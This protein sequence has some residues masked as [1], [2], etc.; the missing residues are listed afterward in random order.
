LDASP[1]AV[2]DKPHCLAE[3]NGFSSRIPVQS[4][5]PF[6]AFNDLLTGH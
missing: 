5:I 6:I 1:A 3:A 4:L 2:A